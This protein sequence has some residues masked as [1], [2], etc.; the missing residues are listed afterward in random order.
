MTKGRKKKQR[1]DNNNIINSNSKQIKKKKE[2][3]EL[4][5]KVLHSSAFESLSE[6]YKFNLFASAILVILCLLLFVTPALV[7][8]DKIIVDL[9]NVIIACMGK[10]PIVRDSPNVGFSGTIA[11]VIVFFEII[12]CK[13]YCS[14]ATKSYN[15]KQ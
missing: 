13:L 8:I 3:F 15:K 12:S 2:V 9:G 10:T 6:A 4:I 1:K 5:E 7:Y 14:K 11:L